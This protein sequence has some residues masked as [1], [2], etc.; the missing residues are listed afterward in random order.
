MS[1][2][3]GSKAKTADSGIQG[4]ALPAKKIAAFGSAYIGMAYT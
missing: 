4:F 2:S 3:Y 1:P